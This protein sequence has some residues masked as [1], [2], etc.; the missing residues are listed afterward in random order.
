MIFNISHISS[1]PLQEQIANQIKSKILLGELKPSEL[2]PS[3]RTLSA[4]LKVS[5][6]TIRRGYE[7]LERDGLIISMQGKGYFVCE[8]DHKE[9]K[10]LAK[11]DLK[12]ALYPQLRKA[13]ENGLSKKEIMG[14]VKD[15][16]SKETENSNGRE[17][18]SA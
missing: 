8:F 17:S 9:R 14:I 5:S 4:E 16:F 7:I 3:I 1:E 18:I 12:D 6:V 10:N 2:L 11:S 13:E 15:F